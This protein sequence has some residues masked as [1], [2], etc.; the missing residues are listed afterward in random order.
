MNAPS[1]RMMNSSAV[2]TSSEPT[3]WGTRDCAPD[4]RLV[5]RP[6]ANLTRNDNIVLHIPATSILAVSAEWEEENLDSYDCRVRLKAEA[7]PIMEWKHVLANSKNSPV[8]D[9]VKERIAPRV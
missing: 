9:S 1:L 7:A 3:F 8:T 6:F 4:C 2:V 5:G